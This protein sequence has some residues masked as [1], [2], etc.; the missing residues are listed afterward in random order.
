MASLEEAYST[1]L[2]GNFP[3]K[4]ASYPIVGVLIGKVV[5]ATYYIYSDDVNSYF[6]EVN[7]KKIPLSIK[8]EDHG[9]EIE[10]PLIGYKYRINFFNSPKMYKN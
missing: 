6:S 4:A 2:M 10:V 7:G 9:K 5:N 3:D 1:I 8:Y